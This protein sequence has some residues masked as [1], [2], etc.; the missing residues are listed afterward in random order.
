MLEILKEHRWVLDILDITLMSII[1]YR[2]LLIVK[3]TKAAQMMTGLA[4]LLLA[5]PGTEY[6]T[7]CILDMNGASYLRT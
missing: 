3:G 1:L 7:G 2:L 6:M 5:S 4:I